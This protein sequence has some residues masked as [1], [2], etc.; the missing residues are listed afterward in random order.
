LNFWLECRDL[1]DLQL[2]AIQLYCITA[3]G[4]NL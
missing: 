2:G 3:T 4:F 1:A